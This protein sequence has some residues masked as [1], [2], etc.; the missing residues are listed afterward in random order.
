VVALAIDPQNPTTVYSGTF[1]SSG[2][3]SQ[4]LFKSDDRGAT[5]LRSDKGLPGQLVGAIA[6]DPV[7]SAVV[8]A[9]TRSPAQPNRRGKGGAVL[10]KSGNAGADWEETGAADLDNVAALAIDPVTPTTLYVGTSLCG[11]NLGVCTG[12]LLKSTNGA[13][14]WSEVLTGD[15][16]ALALDR[17]SPATLYASIGCINLMGCRSVKSTDGGATWNGLGG[18]PGAAGQFLL[19]PLVSGVLYVASS[20]SPV[21]TRVFKST[22]GGVS[23]N[24][25]DSGLSSQISR[26]ATD[27]GSPET[28]YAA[29]L[30]GLFKSTDGGG[31]W[32]ATGLALPATDLAIDPRDPSVLYAATDGGGVLRSPDRGTTWQ[33]INS[34][35][36]VLV[37]NRIVVDSTGG[38]LHATT[39]VGGVYD[40]QLPRLIREAPLR[41]TRMV[42]PRTP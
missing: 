14:S 9:G 42:A 41:P 35:L 29:T 37:V 21:S 20:V 24:A 5:W 6:T 28:L 8:Y 16:V 1:S 38:Y 17:Q 13:S 7:S 26:L 18:F 25:A 31:S 32:S 11:A 19:D 10:Y 34:G 22:D 23:W 30:A 33:A 3:F 36:P 12:K 40:L 27:A 4:G 15:I 39:G 2:T